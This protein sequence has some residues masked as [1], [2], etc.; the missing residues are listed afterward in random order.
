MSASSFCIISSDN[1]RETF[2]NSIFIYFHLSNCFFVLH[3]KLQKKNVQ[4][5]AKVPGIVR[6]EA[7]NKFK[8]IKWRNN[9][10]DFN[11]YH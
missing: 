8:K 6:S 2:R 4:I 10:L 11:I 7:K 9:D 5:S 3:L 1:L